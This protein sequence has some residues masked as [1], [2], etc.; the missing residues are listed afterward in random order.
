MQ[1]IRFGLATLLVLSVLSV[2]RA[3]LFLEVDGVKGGSTDENYVDWIDAKDY[4]IKFVNSG[5]SGSGGGGGAGKSSLTDFFVSAF[6]SKASPEL[7][8]RT[9][10]GEHTKKVELAITENAGKELEY[11]RWTFE[12]VFF[13]S[14]SQSGTDKSVPLD[15]YSLDAS[16]LTYQY[17]EYAPDGALKG[18]ATVSF[19]FKSGKAGAVDIAGDIENFRFFTG[20][21]NV[22]EPATLALAASGMAVLPWLVWRRRQAKKASR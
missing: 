5:N 19:D 7:L 16:K 15:L 20:N 22:P 8:S 13:K 14:F 3:G 4:S 17:K 11:A 6:S 18:T 2:A 9:L 1:A 21:P 12:D 10:T